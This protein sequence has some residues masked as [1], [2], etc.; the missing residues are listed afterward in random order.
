MTHYNC[1]V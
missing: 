1:P